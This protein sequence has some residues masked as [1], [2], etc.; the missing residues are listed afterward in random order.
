[1]LDQPANQQ[2]GNFRGGTFEEQQRD[3]VL[4]LV[5]S[6]QYRDIPQGLVQNY[7]NGGAT[8]EDTIAAIKRTP[9]FNPNIGPLVDTGGGLRTR[10][11]DLAQ[12]NPDTNQYEIVPGQGTS[13]QG[14]K[15][16][17]GMGTGFTTNQ[18]NLNDAKAKLEAMKPAPLPS[19]IN[20]PKV[21]AGTSQPSPLPEL[22]NPTYPDLA[23]KFAGST[24][25][26]VSQ[27]KSDLENTYNTRIIDLKNQEDSITKTIADAQGKLSEA[28]LSGWRQQ[29]QSTLQE[30]YQVQENFDANQR[31]IKEMED[32]MT[33]S[34]A[35]VQ[36]A[37]ATTG[38]KAIKNPTIALMKSDAVARIGVIKAVMA[39]RDRQISTAEKIIDDT[40]R[41]VQADHQDQ[42][43]YY[44]TIMET[45]DKGLIS[46]KSDEKALVDKYI[47]Y[48]ETEQKATEASAQKIKDMMI[49]PAKAQILHDAGVKLT[50]NVE[51]MN[52]KIA[53][54]MNIEN[55]IKIINE[56][57]QKGYTYL[58]GGPGNTPSGDVITMQAP[59][60][61]GTIYFQRP[62]KKGGTTAD[63]RQKILT[64]FHKD[65]SEP[66]KKGE[67]RESY[68]RRL[69]AKYP[70]LKDDYIGQQVYGT[71]PDKYNE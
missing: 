27:G 23:T 10:S 3:P 38:L 71:Y 32:I 25:A 36:A 14:F 1:M 48:L 50:D 8:A 66:P 56:M 55:R 47:S 18:I 5:G 67:S 44:K 58:P 34:N 46:L 51:Q 9:I 39:A 41:V 40:V 37:E 63:D 60:G 28:E 68:I 29:L 42:I 12:L 21:L 65:L 19:T 6:G 11:G 69:K 35:A 31:S 43:N 26:A 2:Y 15:L 70:Q 54:Q 64:E 16:N 30:R 7:V 22:P 52:A 17:E 45:A 62:P 33:S 4:S 49:D 59:G 20:A 24:T 57:G 61:G 53:R 13:D